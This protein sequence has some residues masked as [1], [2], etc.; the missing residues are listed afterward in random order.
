MFTFP[1]SL[2]S[3]S[4]NLLVLLWY[5]INDGNTESRLMRNLLGSFLA[6]F[7]FFHPSFIKIILQQKHIELLPVN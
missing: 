7:Y 1:D 4:C 5:L 3:T 6:G 2:L